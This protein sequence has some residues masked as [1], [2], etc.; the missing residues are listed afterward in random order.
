MNNEELILLLKAAFAAGFRYGHD[1]G[2]DAEWGHGCSISNKPQ[3][4]D[5]AWSEDVQWRID[6]EHSYHLDVENPK[7][8]DSIPW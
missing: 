4:P 8:W 6:T 7:H 3:T 5:K 2:A 1:A